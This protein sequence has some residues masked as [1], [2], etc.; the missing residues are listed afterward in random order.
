MMGCAVL[1]CAGSVSIWHAVG[2]MA[3]EHS[4][5]T[6]TQLWER[7]QASDLCHQGSADRRVSF[8]FPGKAW[9]GRAT[10]PFLW[11]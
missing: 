2:T 9:A 11:K 10:K 1:C 4:A 6:W 5:S 3:L 8:S 7:P